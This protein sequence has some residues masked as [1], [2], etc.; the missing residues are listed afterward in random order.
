VFVGSPVLVVADGWITRRGVGV[1]VGGGVV[2]VGVDA[3]N[4]VGVQNA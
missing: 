4:D 2:E 1:E 3:G